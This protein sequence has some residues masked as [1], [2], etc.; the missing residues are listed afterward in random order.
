MWNESSWIFNIKNSPKNLTSYLSLEKVPFFS[1]S[2][3]CAVRFFF[4]FNLLIPVCL[5]APTR[6]LIPTK[7]AIKIRKTP[8]PR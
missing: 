2:G 1:S 6:G 7:I 8:V 4:T 5:L 3:L